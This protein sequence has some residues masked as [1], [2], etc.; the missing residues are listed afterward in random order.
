MNIEKIKKN[1]I[2][3]FII[4]GTLAVF[5]STFAFC[6]GWS[7][8]DRLVYDMS[9]TVEM[10]RTGDNTITY[11]ELIKLKN[12]DEF[13]YVTGYSEIISGVS[14]R[15]GISEGGIKVVLTD[16]EYA[17]AYKYDM[18]AG[19]FPDSQAVNRGEAYAVISD[20]LA[21]KLFKSIDVVG[22]EINV[23]GKEYTVAGLYKSSG[24]GLLSICGD[25]FDRMFIPYSSVDNYGEKVVDVITLLR[26]PEQGIIEVKTILDK[27]IGSKAYSHRL[28]DHSVSSVVIHQY[29][30][31]LLF[32][33]GAFT[34]IRRGK[35]K[36]NRIS[37][38]YRK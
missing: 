25:G 17:L 6:T 14:N 2:V 4:T 37:F 10:V 33:I 5:M 21:V 16:A 11:K 8:S 38:M 36:R 15:F 35:L 22:S 7:F 34:I 1:T 23:L 27:Y 20:L 3:K 30:D 24:S 29:F 19:S 28:I 26:K 9:Q 12:R 13:H 31:L 18:L 32:A